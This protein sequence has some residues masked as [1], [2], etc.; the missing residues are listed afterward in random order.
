[1]SRK[2]KRMN[3]SNK[4][5]M[6]KQILDIFL[7]GSSLLGRYL[8]SFICYLF[9]V[10]IRINITFVGA[11]ISLNVHLLFS[12]VWGFCWALLLILS[13]NRSTLILSLSVSYFVLLNV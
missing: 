1:M 5:T 11:R 2:E 7:S 6:H 9:V 13:T 3:K 10:V 8:Y 4:Q 12:F